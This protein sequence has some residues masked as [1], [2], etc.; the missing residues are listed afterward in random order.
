MWQQLK[1]PLPSTGAQQP[2]LPQIQTSPPLGLG[3]LSC[4]NK[5]THARFTKSA[6]RGEICLK[7]CFQVA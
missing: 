4:A 5:K 6:P 7:C 1:A 2:Q 3:F